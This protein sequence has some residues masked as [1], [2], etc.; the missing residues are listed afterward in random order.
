MKTL[1]ID[2][3]N[4]RGERGLRE[5][6]PVATFWGSTQF[7]PQPQWLLAARATD[8]ADS[9]YFAMKDIHGI[10]STK[11][12]YESRTGPSDLD[13]D[14]HKVGEL[15]SVHVVLDENKRPIYVTGDRHDA[16]QHINEAISEH[17]IDEA[18]RWV[19]REFKQ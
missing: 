5:I 17:D 11:E 4:H 9:R 3:T 12:D 19:V 15:Q 7:H 13:Y 10:Y 1:W 8:R 6:A 18:A 14:P 16:H 2:Y